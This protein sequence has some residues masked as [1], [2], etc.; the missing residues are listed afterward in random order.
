MQMQTKVYLPVSLRHPPQTHSSSSFS[1]DVCAS[2]SVLQSVLAT[3]CLLLGTV[4]RLAPSQTCSAKLDWQNA[5]PP[6]LSLSLS[7]HCR[8]PTH[9]FIRMPAALASSSMSLFCTT[10]E[11]NTLKVCP[12]TSRR[13]NNATTT[14]AGNKWS[15]HTFECLVIMQ[16][17]WRQTQVIYKQRYIKA[18]YQVQS[19]GIW[20]STVSPE[21]YSILYI[22]MNRQK[23]MESETPCLAVCAL[24]DVTTQ[25]GTSSTLKVVLDR[26]YSMVWSALQP[27][28][29]GHK[30]LR[31]CSTELKINK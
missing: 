4:P 20:T 11:I 14:S 29:G 16:S 18:P 6:H 2:L 10:A 5:P 9:P 28:A 13:K 31:S 22:F 25:Y 17:H 24:T 30:L 8:F 15:T 19:T 3:L 21:M 7:S 12:P 27:T 23:K 26:Q 1:P